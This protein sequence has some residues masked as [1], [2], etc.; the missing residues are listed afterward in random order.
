MV[1]VPVAPT[2]RIMDTKRLRDAEAVLATTRRRLMCRILDA[3]AAATADS[4]FIR[5][6]V[7]AKVAA[8][9]D[10]T[11]RIRFTWRTRD[12]ETAV[13]SAHTRPT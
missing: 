2:A 12:G 8:P 5:T 7:Y 13:S 6:R 9:A 4:D 3:V 11:A 10:E 1:A